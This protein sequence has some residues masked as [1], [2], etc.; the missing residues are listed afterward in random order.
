MGKYEPI[1]RKLKQASNDEYC[2]SLSEIEE[3]LGFKLPA[4]ARKHRAWW[5]NSYKGNH[6]QA[7]GW[8]GAGW[9]T[10]DIDV[11]RERVRFVRTEGAGRS[12]RGLNNLDLWDKARSLTGIHDRMELE[13]AAV[14]ALLQQ[15]AVEELIKLGGTMP[16]LVIP[17]R[18][19]PSL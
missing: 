9:E 13:A 12:H 15:V 16:D 3:I 17:A 10:R 8:I 5:S 18:E 14:R 19:R 4:S 2:A 6:S 7:E 1:A 11:K